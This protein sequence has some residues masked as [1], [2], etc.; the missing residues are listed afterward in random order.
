MNWL[1]ELHVFACETGQALKHWSTER[2]AQK[3]LLRLASRELADIGVSR[4]SIEH[5]VKNGRSQ[6]AAWHQTA[7]KTQAVTRKPTQL[8]KQAVCVGCTAKFGHAA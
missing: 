7:C 1:F 2:K 4:S 8:K 3:D 5:S 6:G